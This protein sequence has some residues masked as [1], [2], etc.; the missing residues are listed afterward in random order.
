MGRVLILQPN[1]RLVGGRYWDFIDHRV[2][3]TDASLLEAAE[4]A[5]FERERLIV[6]F[7]PYTTKRRLPQSPWLVRWYLRIPIAWRLLAGQ[8]LYVGRLR[9]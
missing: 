7:L 9:R 8:S 5:G 6:R 1:I 3:L 4:L 2:A